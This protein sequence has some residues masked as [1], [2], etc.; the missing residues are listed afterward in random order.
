MAGKGGRPSRF[1][2][3]IADQICER[4]ADGESLRTI[5]SDDS[6]PN[7]S[8]VFRWLS[9]NK[10]FCSQY[11]RAREAQADALADEILDIADNNAH[12][13]AVDN[14]GN[15]TINHDAIARSRLR[16]DT[17][18]WLAGKLKPKVYGDKIQQEL[19]GKN[20]GPVEYSNL[21]DTELDRRLNALIG[22]QKTE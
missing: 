7:R 8:T 19:T 20:G 14:E 21:S 6:M 17:R 4:L 18:K 10:E 2:L 15:E 1:T 12:D 9:Q 22:H 3:N 13:I 11:A 16:V 5:C